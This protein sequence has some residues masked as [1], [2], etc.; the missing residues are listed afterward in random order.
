MTIN[1]G[2]AEDKQWQLFEPKGRVLTL[3]GASLRF[4]KKRFRPSEKGFG[5]Q[6]VERRCTGKQRRGARNEI[7]VFGIRMG[8]DVD[9]PVTKKEMVVPESPLR[10]L[11]GYEVRLPSK[12]MRSRGMTASHVAVVGYWK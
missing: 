8:N 7:P 3:P 6:P 1:L 9:N 5:Q 12:P 11:R 2:E 4:I 10:H